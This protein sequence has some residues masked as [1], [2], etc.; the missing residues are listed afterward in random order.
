MELLSYSLALLIGLSLGLIG[1]GGSILTVPIFV[2]VFHFDPKVAIAMSLAVVGTTSLVG[3][4]GHWRA[5]NVNLKIALLFGSV[6][7]VGTYVGARLATFFS[8]SA[9]LML[10]AVV[11]LASAAAMLRDKQAEPA[12]PQEGE[13]PAPLNYPLIAA[14]GLAVGA[15]TGLVGVGGGFLVVPALVLLGKVP[16]KQAIGTSLVVIALKSAAGFIG[17]L[18]QVQVDWTFMA[19]FTGLASIGIFLGTYLVRFVSASALKRGFAI[20]LLVM[21]AFIL[22]QN[23]HVLLS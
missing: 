7:M 23:R 15:L 1:G 5:G 18:G 16:M 14:E 12:A 2:Y 4:F 22:F 19:I 20:F 3:A 21:G 11:M 8:G 9:Q 13:A 17:Y 6:A 10:F